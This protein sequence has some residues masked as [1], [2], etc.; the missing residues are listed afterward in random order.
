MF[1]RLT[2]MAFILLYPDAASGTPTLGSNPP[3]PSSRPP[4]PVRFSIPLAPMP[5]GRLRRRAVGVSAAAFGANANG[6]TGQVLGAAPFG[7]VVCSGEID[8]EE[9][10]MCEQDL[11]S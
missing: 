6:A 8:R 3:V 2:S 5:C 10:M 11:S 7:G 4:R 9:F 1:A